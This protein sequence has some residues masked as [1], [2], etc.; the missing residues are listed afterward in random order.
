M[1]AAHPTTMEG[2]ENLDRGFV[3][4]AIRS[5]V[6]IV[7]D[8]GHGYG[9]GVVVPHG[10]VEHADPDVKKY[11]VAT[12]YHIFMDLGEMPDFHVRLPKTGRKKFKAFLFA[13][14]P[15]E[16]LA[17]VGFEIKKEDQ[18]D[19]NSLPVPAVYPAEKSTVKRNGE[20]VFAVGFHFGT[21][22]KVTKGVYAGWN[23]GKHIKPSIIL[24]VRRNGRMH[25]TSK[26]SP[27]SSGGGLYS[28][29]DGSLQGI[30]DSALEDSV[31]ASNLIFAIPITVLV[32]MIALLE[33]RGG[34]DEATVVVRTPL[35]GF[36]TRPVEY[37][38]RYNM[39]ENVRRLND[40]KNP[41]EKIRIIENGAYV[42]RVL[43]NSAAKDAEFMTGSVI[44]HVIV[45][46]VEYKLSSDGGCARVD[47]AFEPVS[48]FGLLMRLPMNKPVTFKGWKP[49]DGDSKFVQFHSI[50]N[51][52]QRP[53]TGALKTTYAPFEVHT[54]TLSIGAIQVEELR[55]NHFDELF[56]DEI[57]EDIKAKRKVGMY[58]MAAI[59]S[60]VQ[61]KMH[62]SHLV[63]SYVEP[64]VN[65][66]T[67]IM[68]FGYSLLLKINEKHVSSFQEVEIVYSA[69]LKSDDTHFNIT[70]W[71]VTGVHE[72]SLYVDRK[73]RAL[74]LEKVARN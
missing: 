57:R 55:M 31:G 11:L 23:I 56:L 69:I 61:D 29:F 19:E 45:G 65:R 27:G 32:D 41:G 63:I 16:D 10:L 67:K 52:D 58:S 68:A 49:S 4:R 28:S 48:L 18:I 71:N 15:T 72:V 39:N 38:L 64:S 47:W 12:N 42:T 54:R 21:T 2:G 5:S 50:L 40:E 13:I 44:T 9:S 30:T 8:D 36:C 46:D 70:F 62:Q 73:P 43:E 34:S 6:K 35:F 26:T 3:D 17:L 25:I 37:E 51:R 20:G 33:P 1:G 7:Y 66:M 74:S 14:F 59:R 60:H 53:Y 24:P 22:L